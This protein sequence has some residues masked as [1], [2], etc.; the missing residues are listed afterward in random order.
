M[1]ASSAVVRICSLRKQ[2][3]EMISA[4]DSNEAEGEVIVLLLLPKRGVSEA[5]LS[6]GLGVRRWEL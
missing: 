6:R 4:I 2:G 3:N 5:I 1:S